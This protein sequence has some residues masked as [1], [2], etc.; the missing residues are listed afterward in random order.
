MAGGPRASRGG[1]GVIRY[2]CTTPA[3]LMPLAVDEVAAHLRITDETE[4]PLLDT[5]LRVAVDYLERTTG[6]RLLTQTWTAVLDQGDVPSGSDALELRGAP[7]ASITSIAY[8]DTGGVSQTWV[9][10]NYVVDTGRQPGRVYPAYLVSW[11]DVRDQP[12]AMTITYVCGWT[13]ATAVPRPIAHALKLLVGHWYENR[14][15]TTPGDSPQD[16]P[17]AYDALI[18]PYR[19]WSL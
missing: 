13:A 14:E 2:S 11:P 7:L 5:Y 1:L 15:A 12:Q 10:S 16:V 19:Q 3:V 4:H 9:S 18:A 6:L 8:V 17:R